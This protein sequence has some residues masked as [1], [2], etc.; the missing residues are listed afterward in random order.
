M[1]EV[2]G[3]RLL[4]GR[5]DDEDKIRMDLLSPV[6]L[7]GTA[8]VLTFGAKKYDAYNWAK[9]IAYSRVFAAL[10][11]HLWAFWRGEDLDEETGMP[12]LWHASCCLM[13]LTHYEGT[14]LRGFDDRP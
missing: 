14:N 6:F 11:R 10:Q 12:H 4:E 9:G 3:H 8:M 7:E 13:F 2:E 5:K 1:S